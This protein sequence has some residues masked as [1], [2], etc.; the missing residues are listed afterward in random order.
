[1]IFVS[2]YDNK[3]KQTND[4]YLQ[5][6]WDYGNLYKDSRRGDKLLCAACNRSA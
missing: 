4:I 6:Q 1:M 2:Y 5:G 3:R